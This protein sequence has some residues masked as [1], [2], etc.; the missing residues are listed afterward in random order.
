M[1]KAEAAVYKSSKGKCCIHL[2]YICWTWTYTW[3]SVSC[4]DMYCACFVKLCV[5]HVYT[6]WLV[7]QGFFLILLMLFSWQFHLL[8]ARK[9]Y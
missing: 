9:H 2:L 7:M 6:S 8:Y 5:L 1:Q 4:C 3:C